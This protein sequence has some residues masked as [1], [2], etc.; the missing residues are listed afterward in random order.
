[1]RINPPTK[2]YIAHSSIHGLG[3]FASELI[4]EGEIIEECPVHD[5]KI[6]VGEITS[7]MIDYRYNWPQGSDNWF[8]QV[9]SWGYGSIY[10][11]SNTPNSGWRSNIDKFTFEFYAIRDI[12]PD[13]EIFTWYGD[14]NYWNDG[15]VHTNVM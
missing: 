11:H 12:L 7:L 5:L 4:K 14:I 15:R 6:P 8:L 1:M 9:L 3:V 2:I 13:E 10:N